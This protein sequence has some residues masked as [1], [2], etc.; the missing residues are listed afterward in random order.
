M[1]GPIQKFHQGVVKNQESA[2]IYNDD[3][4]QLGENNSFRELLQCK[5]DL[6]VCL[7]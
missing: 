6:G 2:I 3:V 4:I 5:A 1:A 7:G